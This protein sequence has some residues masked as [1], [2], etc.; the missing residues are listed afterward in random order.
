MR[1]HDRREFLADVGR[2]MLV[3][4]VGAA[5][6][7]DMGLGSARAAGDGSALGFGKLEPLVAEMQQTPA[8]R[9]VPALVARLKDGT[10]L[11]TL[12]TR[13]CCG[14]RSASACRR[15]STTGTG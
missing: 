4:S 3:G 12:A 15:S 13:R 9:L 7:A 8:A 5:L 1:S 2:G 11:D 10:G 14:S 6:A